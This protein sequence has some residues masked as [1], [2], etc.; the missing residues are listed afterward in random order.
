MRPITAAA[1][2]AVLVALTATPALAETTGGPPVAVDDAVSL[3]NIATSQWVHPLDNDS[4]PDGD[5]LTYTAVTPGTKGTTFVDSRYPSYL[6]YR[7]HPGATA[8]TDSF[9]YTVTDGNG[10]TATGTVTVTLWDEL[11]PPSGLSIQEAGPGAVTLTWPAVPGAT[12]YRVHG[13]GGAVTTAGPSFTATGLSDATFYAW[14]V[15]AVNGGGFES[16]WS[17]QGVY[18]GSRLATPWDVRVDGTADP[19]ALS[20]SWDGESDGPWNVYRD[21]LLLTTVTDKEYLDTG[22]VTDRAYSYQVQNGGLSTSTTVYPPSLLS[23][24]VTGTPRLLSSIGLLHVDL[25]GSGGPLGPVTV[26]ERAIPGGRQQDHSHGVIVQ[27]D[28]EDPFSVRDASAT[29]YASA[30]GAAGDL[31]FPLMESECGLRDFGC[32]Q[33]FEGGSIWSSSYTSTRVVR[34]VIEDGWAATGYEEGPL[35][36]PTVPQVVIRGGVMQRFEDGGVYWSPATGSHGV[37]G[38]IW[39]TWSATGW[40]FGALGYPVTDEVCG[41]RD[42]GCFQHFQRGSIYSTPGTGTHAVLGGI[43]DSWARAGWEHSPLGY[44][45]T[46]QVCGLRDGGCFQ[47]FQGGSVYSTPAT[48]AQHVLGGFRDAWARAGWEH[49][50][51]G[52]PVTGQ[53]CGLRDGGCFQHFQRGS[54]YSTPA[55]G[56]QLLLGGIRDAWARAG[57]EHS[58]LGYP[59]SGQVCGLRDGGCFQHFQRGSIYSTPA[60]GPQL[61]LGGFRDAWARAGWEHSPLGYP[62]S[63]QV[64]GLRDGGCFQH[65]QRGSIYATPRTGAQ[66]VVGAVR[67]AWARAGWEHSRLGYPLAAETASGSI[68]QQRFQGGTITVDLATGRTRIG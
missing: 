19:T 46:G 34:Q 56:P 6:N 55:T 11:A 48:G 47:H 4:D 32:F 29:E 22:L 40:E 63:G 49:S 9:T 50:P 31:G 13:N 1:A 10:N 53:V 5:R 20:L 60:T 21:G 7:P 39:D 28:G 68:R 25:G 24:P 54:I 15:G 64:C 59:V 12:S 42:G 38:P 8:G 45:V 62:V 57:W 30:G 3:R 17:P 43:R 44:P 52:Y 16:S 58:P 23:G 18:R 26:P 66:P 41:L 67:D 2:A 35:G 27:R 37:S 33:L 36:Y 65:F 61:V 14:Y 51:L